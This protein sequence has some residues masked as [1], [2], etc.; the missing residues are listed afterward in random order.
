M[1]STWQTFATVESSTLLNGRY[2]RRVAQNRKLLLNAMF[3][4]TLF[5]NLA[6]T[7]FW[8]CG[9]DFNR[10]RTGLNRNWEADWMVYFG[11]FTLVA[12]LV[13]LV[14][15]MVAFKRCLTICEMIIPLFC[16]FERA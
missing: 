12:G 10:S 11:I 1:A 14:V 6:A 7:V 16:I 9:C 5:F 4:W 2:R 3:I 8:V 13:G 15:G